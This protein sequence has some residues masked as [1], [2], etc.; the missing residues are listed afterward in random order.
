MFVD[1]CVDWEF[2]ENLPIWLS[3]GNFFLLNCGSSKEKK[4]LGL[5]WVLKEELGFWNQICLFVELFSWVIL[6]ER[7]W[8]HEAIICLEISTR[9]MVFWEEAK[10][11]SNPLKFLF[12]NLNKSKKKSRTLVVNVV[13]THPQAPWW[14]QLWVQRWRQRKEKELG[15]TPWLTALR[16]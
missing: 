14:T 15:H 13:V 12:C 5:L 6:V 4:I 10:E 7:A 11:S 2:W 16:G 8:V 3:L 9:L 1:L